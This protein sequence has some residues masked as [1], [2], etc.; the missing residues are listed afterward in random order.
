MMAEPRIKAGLWVKMVLRLGQ[1]D[2]RFAAVLKRGD[3]DAGGIL[4]VLRSRDGLSVL[5]QIRTGD[6][7][8]AWL[9][10]TGAEPVDQ[11]TADAYVARQVKF[12]P[13]LWVLEFEAA[14]LLPP[15]DGKIV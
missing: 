12:D 9:R 4:A 2:G 6:G 10:A 8:A 7:E 14:D 11:D 3:A 15:F 5:S 13:D 1:A